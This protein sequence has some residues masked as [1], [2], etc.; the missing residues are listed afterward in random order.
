MSVLSFVCCQVEASASGRSLVQRS[1]TACD[2]AASIMRSLWSARGCC[3]MGGGWGNCYVGPHKFHFVLE[4]RWF[5]SKWYNDIQIC[6]S[7]SYGCT[8]DMLWIIII[9]LWMFLN[10]IL[11][12]KSNLKSRDVIFSVQNTAS[13]L[14]A[15]HHSPITLTWQHSIKNIAVHKMTKAR[16][17]FIVSYMFL[18]LNGYHHTKPV[19]KWIYQGV[20]YTNRLS[21]GCRNLP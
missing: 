3:A 12:F 18:H 15:F 21:Q 2:P 6:S 10:L 5:Y 16:H 17:L 9:R 7:P 13:Y 8:S 11:V 19:N 20:V 4:K 14:G 1:P